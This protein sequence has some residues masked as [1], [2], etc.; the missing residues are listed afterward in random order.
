M[1]DIEDLVLAPGAR[2]KHFILSYFKVLPLLLLLMSETQTFA[3]VN[4]TA[5]IPKAGQVSKWQ[6]CRLET[7]ALVH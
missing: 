6:Y 3:K 2:F 1:E 7:Q 4:S 5:A